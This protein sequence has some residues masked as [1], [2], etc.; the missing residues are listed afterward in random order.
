MPHFHCR[1]GFTLLKTGFHL[2]LFQF[3]GLIL[4]TS[5]ETI[6]CNKHKH[7]LV[8]FFW[9]S[10]WLSMHCKWFSNLNGRSH[11]GLNLSSVYSWGRWKVQTR[12][13]ASEGIGSPLLPQWVGVD[14]TALVTVLAATAPCCWDLLHRH[15]Q[16]PWNPAP[17]QAGFL[18]LLFYKLNI[19]QVSN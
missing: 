16:C 17:P 4:P 19:L 11:Q 15:M 3:S 2:Y 6:K 1:S 7:F 10:S 9:V 14:E 8:L 18:P 5:Y 12:W 13:M